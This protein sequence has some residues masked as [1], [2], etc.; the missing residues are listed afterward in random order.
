M[1]PHA[2]QCPARSASLEA[3][4]GRLTGA[5][6][7]L[8][9][10]SA[11]GT[12]GAREGV[13]HEFAAQIDAAVGAAMIEDEL[14]RDPLEPPSSPRGSKRGGDEDAVAAGPGS[15]H[16]FAVDADAAVKWLSVLLVWASF[17]VGMAGS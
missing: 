12:C 4:V 7:T 14:S 11:L 15:E 2:T 17:F 3:V 9:S 1:A 6:P 16:G 10:V 8:A 5:V 13:W